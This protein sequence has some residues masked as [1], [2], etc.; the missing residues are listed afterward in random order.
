[1][2]KSALIVLI[3]VSSL[4]ISQLINKIPSPQPTE[5]TFMICLGAPCVTK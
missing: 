2:P 1:M 4:V 3:I 5:P